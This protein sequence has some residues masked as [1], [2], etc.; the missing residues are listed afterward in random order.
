MCVCV[1]VC[2][3]VYLYICMLLAQMMTGLQGYIHVMKCIQTVGVFFSMGVAELLQIF[4]QCTLY[5]I[6]HT[7]LFTSQNFTLHSAV[8]CLRQ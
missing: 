8:Y 6:Y 1:C 4:I 7:I 3:C 5:N 2:V